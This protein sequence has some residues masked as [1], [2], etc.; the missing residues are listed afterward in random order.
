MDEVKKWDLQQLPSYKAIEEPEKTEA[1]E[2]EKET[3]AIEE[4]EENPQFL[5]SFNDMEL[6]NGDVPDYENNDGE[7]LTTVRKKTLDAMLSQGNFDEVKYEIN[8]IDTNK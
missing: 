7:Q 3:E 5:I 6:I 1:I 4:Y 8:F 2:E